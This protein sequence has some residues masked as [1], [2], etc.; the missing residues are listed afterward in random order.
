MFLSVV[1]DARFFSPL[2]LPLPVWDDVPGAGVVVV[3][4]VTPE[5]SV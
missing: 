3:T 2:P 1:V 5:E 4:V